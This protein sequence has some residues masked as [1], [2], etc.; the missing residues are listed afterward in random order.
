MLKG[1]RNKLKRS[2]DAIESKVCS[3][4]AKIGKNKMTSF[5]ETRFLVKAMVKTWCHR[6]L[7]EYISLNDKRYSV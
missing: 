5:P 1:G 2:C 3:T 4:N 6:S 7:D